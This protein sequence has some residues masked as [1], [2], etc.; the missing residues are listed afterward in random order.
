M[1]L[2]AVEHFREIERTELADD[3]KNRQRKA[4]IADAVY[5][6]RLVAGVGRVLLQKIEPDQQVA[7][8]SHA[9]PSD[10]Q[11]QE[12]LRQHQNQHEKHEQVQVCEEAVIAALVRHVADGIN[13]DQQADSGDHHQH[14]GGQPVHRE[15][16]ADVQIA[17]L[18]PGEVVLDVFRF[19]RAQPQQRLH[20][21]SER[22]RH[23]TDG[24]QIDQRLGQSPAEE[25]VEQEAEERE[26]G[27]QPEEYHESQYFIELTSSI[28]SVW[29]F[30]NTVKIIAKPNRRLRRRY[31]HHKETEDVPVHLFEL[32]REGNEGQIHR[33]EH[34]LDGHENGDDV[35][36]INKARHS[37]PEQNGA[38]NQVPSG[39]YRVVHH[40]NL[41]PR[42]HDRAQNSDQDENRGDFKGQ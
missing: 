1:C 7:A 40:L 42:K 11:Q 34:Q 16:D 20:R 21:P 36:P 6:E 27:D 3:Q 41:L 37:Q 28:M 31:H 38:E 9:F 22:Q 13:M 5:D 26:D 19:E 30:L 39:R 35:A 25:T 18:N 12:I 2:A 17:A 15:I 24:E 8:Q 23:R 29:R 33:V 14:H 32:V 10:E 4:E